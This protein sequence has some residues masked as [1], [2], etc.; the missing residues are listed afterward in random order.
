[1]IFDL[2]S[3]KVFFT[4]AGFEL[5]P[6]PFNN[7]ARVKF[8]VGVGCVMKGSFMCHQLK[9]FFRKWKHSLNI[10]AG[11]FSVFR[12]DLSIW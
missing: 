11:L 8:R 2:P 4:L 12:H 9:S 3:A 10:H 5:L 1:M 7:E 6:L